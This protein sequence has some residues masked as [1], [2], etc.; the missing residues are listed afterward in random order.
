M[1]LI[2]EKFPSLPS[3]KALRQYRGDEFS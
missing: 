2:A 3:E 1:K